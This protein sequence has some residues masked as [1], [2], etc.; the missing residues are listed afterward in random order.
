MIK[1]KNQWHLDGFLY[2]LPRHSDD[3]NFKLG[4][5]QKRLHIYGVK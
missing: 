1:P 5:L 4:T 3:P 2:D